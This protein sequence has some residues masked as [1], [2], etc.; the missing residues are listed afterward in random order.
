[1]V[2]WPLDTEDV[3]KN[4]KAQVRDHLRFVVADPEDRPFLP[5]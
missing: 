2:G 4:K 3:Y 5:T 1:M